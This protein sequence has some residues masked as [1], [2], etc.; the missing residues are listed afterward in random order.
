MTSPSRSAD[1]IESPQYSDTD[2]E[3]ETENVEAPTNKRQRDEAEDT[4]A[5]RQMRRREVLRAKNREAVLHHKREA[6]RILEEAKAIR[7]Q[8]E[9]AE[10]RKVA[11]TSGS[12]GSWRSTECRTT[13]QWR[14]FY[15]HW[16]EAE[17]AERRT[18]QEM[19]KMWAHTKAAAEK[20]A[21][22]AAEE[23]AKVKAADEEAAKVKAHHTHTSET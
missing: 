11:A 8:K 3:N 21:K 20:A 12:S 7:R 1:A 4:E 5:T 15:Y 10:V 14:E 17:K 9:I 18:R 2:V 13:G 19:R 16:A 23:A 22:A 6:V